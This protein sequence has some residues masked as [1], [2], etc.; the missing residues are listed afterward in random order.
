MRYLSLSSEIGKKKK[1]KKGANSS[2]CLFQCRGSIDGCC[3]R[4]L[5]SALIQIPVPSR[6]TLID[7]PEI[8]FNL[9]SVWGQLNIKVTMTRRQL[10]S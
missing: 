10:K 6:N 2:S 3:L 9:G 4:T 8:M 1:R 5:E 7:I